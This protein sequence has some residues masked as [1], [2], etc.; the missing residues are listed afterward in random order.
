MTYSQALDFLYQQL[1]MYQ[2]VGAAAFKKD[3]TNTLALC[4]HL[5]NPQQRFKTVHVAG[6]N[7]KGSSAH[8]IAA[9]LQSAGY[10][11]GLY[12]SPHLKDFSETHSGQRAAYC[13]GGS[14]RFCA[15]A[16]GLFGTATAFFL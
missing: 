6:T 2:R 15:S 16:P 7:G 1:P 13:P 5:G 12:T 3:L 8:S 4:A 10:R 11:V 9:V 14:H